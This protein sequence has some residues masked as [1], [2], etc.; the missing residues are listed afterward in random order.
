MQTRK[1]LALVLSALAAT[2]AWSAPKD[3]TFPEDAARIR[4]IFAA[5]DRLQPGL[6]EYMGHVADDMILMPNGG[7]I[8]EG[9]AAYLQH[10]KDFYAAGSIQI[11][12]ELVEAYSYPEVV[13]ARG[14]AVGKFTPPG[15]TESSFE[16]RNMFVFRR[17][18]DGSLQVWQIIYN[19]APAG[20]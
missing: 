18:K 5:H 6:E 2:L 11:R 8:V 19:N 4:A 9:K 1:V 20:T 12:H 17:L 7:S 15:G 16:T 10:V 14:R 3:Q 13:I